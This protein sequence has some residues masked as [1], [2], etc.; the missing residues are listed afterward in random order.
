VIA[1]LAGA[2]TAG[3][4]AALVLHAPGSEPAGAGRLAAGYGL[5]ALAIV[6]LAV[7]ASRSAAGRMAGMGAGTAL[8]LT[9]ALG[10]LNAPLDY[11]VPVASALRAGDPVHPTDDPVNDRGL[12]AELYT[13]LR[14]IRDHT[15]SD[16]VIAV[17]NHSLNSTGLES[18]Y[19]YYS[20]LTERRVFLESWLYAPE[21]H[22]LGYERVA[23]GEV[24]P[25]PE[26][27][28]L[29]DAAFD[30]AGP[31]ALRELRTRYG[32]DYLV[33]DKLHGTASPRLR[34]LGPPAFENEAV[35]VYR[36]DAG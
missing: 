21:S 1:L 31:A 6:A 17:N 9:I 36:L 27:M 29:N 8:L 3:A 23:R 18:R 15:S 2:L 5:A 22:E 4:V 19:Y 30:R 16:D 11:G 28:A 7:W 25:F 26:R 12:T 14:W 13:G 20:A 35:T 34:R 33:V 32:V 24:F 10:A